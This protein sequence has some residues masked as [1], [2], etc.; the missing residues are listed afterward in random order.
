[1]NTDVE[2]KKVCIT[3]DENQLC[4]LDTI[5]STVRADHAAAWANN[6]QHEEIRQIIKAKVEEII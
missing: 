5:I 2:L 3:L 6:S 1:M 4:L